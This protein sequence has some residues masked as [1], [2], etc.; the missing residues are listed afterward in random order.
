MDFPTIENPGAGGS[1][2]SNKSDGTPL[3][4]AARQLPSCAC[5]AG[6]ATGKQREF[7]EARERKNAEKV[8]AAIDGFRSGSGPECK[9]LPSLDRLQELFTYDPATGI[10]K[11]K[12]TFGGRIE[13]KACGCDSQG[14]KRVSVDGELYLVHR[15]VFKLVYHR[16]PVG[17]LD[18]A[19]GNRADN[20][21]FR[22]DPDNSNLREATP[23]E[24]SLNKCAPAGSNTGHRGISKLAG[25]GKFL[26]CI[27]AGNIVV[28]LGSFNCLRCA[29]DA[30]AHAF[31]LLI[32]SPANNNKGEPK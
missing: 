32:G 12:E 13:G 21:L 24:N 18:H 14:Y 30:R 25:T 15:L 22:D 10:L 20:R 19:N 2:V 7:D 26:A 23:W 6:N 31:V 17:G 9:P 27:G 8:L 11:W 5:R 29:I 4:F 1:G 3:K 28:K 16:D